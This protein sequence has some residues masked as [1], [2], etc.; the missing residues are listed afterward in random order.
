MAQTRPSIITRMWGTETSF[1]QRFN[2]H[3]V[4][5]GESHKL[6]GGGAQV[7]G[8]A[9]FLTASF[10]EG[11]GDIPGFPYGTFGGC[12]IA[13]SIDHQTPSPQRITAFAIGLL[14]PTN[15]WEVRIFNQ[16]SVAPA[17]E[18]TATV[19]LP[20]GFAMTSGGARVNYSGN[21]GNFLIASLPSNSARGWDVRAQDYRLASPATATAFVIGIRPRNQTA[22]PETRVRL[23]MSPTSETPS[24][25]VDVMRGFS[26][27]GGGARVI[28]SASVGGVLMTS[29]FP[30]DATHWSGSAM[31]D[32]L[33]RNGKIQVYSVSIK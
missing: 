31:Q 19:R 8:P 7:N 5:V 33:H 15:Q 23:I 17:S 9:N 6:I 24:A 30:S 20:P 10:P 1:P 25:T 21:I 11:D 29:S 28:P 26:L 3:R 32:L 14:D 27:S 12:W 4:C 18:P 22:L 13:R 2:D 16:T